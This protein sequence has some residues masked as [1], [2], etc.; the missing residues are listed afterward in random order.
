MSLTLIVPESEN[1][2]KLTKDRGVDKEKET[3]ESKVDN[4]ED[5]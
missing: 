1:K 2:V 4:V 5:P 3:A